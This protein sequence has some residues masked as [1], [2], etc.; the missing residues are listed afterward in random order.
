MNKGPRKS[1]A[2]LRD[3]V[4]YSGSECLIWPFGRRANGYGHLRFGGNRKS[5]SA[6]RV[7]CELAYGPPPFPKAVVSHT[8]G[9]G[10]DGCVN[11]KH[12]EWATQRENL[13]LKTVHGTRQI[14]SKNGFAKL[15][16]EQVRSI[17]TS[18]EQG[19]ELARKFG[20]ST[21]AISAIRVGRNWGWLNVQEG[22]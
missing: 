20:V 4:D 18:E 7:M 21:C 17:K 15:N 5:W 8:C 3:R 19:V 6:H 12:L 11:P 13:A 22:V 2:W 14:G 16:E 9:K 1:E 10:G